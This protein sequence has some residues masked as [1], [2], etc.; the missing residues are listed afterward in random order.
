M[1]EISIAVTA[2]L[3]VLTLALARRF[4]AIPLLLGAT[5]V[6]RGAEMELG[7]A[8][9][10]IIRVLIAVG[11]VRV[12]LRG[13]HL[14]NGTNSIDRALVLWAIVLMASSIAHTPDAW[15]YRAGIVW[16]VLGS[17][18]LLRV[19]LRDW[20]DVTRIFK[21]LCIALVPVAVLMILE[22][23]TGHNFFAALG[24]DSQVVV[25]DGIVRARG[26]FA[27]PILAGTVG[28]TSVAMALSLW[29]S[30]RVHA[31]FGLLAASGILLACTSSG[32]AVSA[33]FV[34][35]GLML[36]KSRKKIRALVW[37]IA[38]GIAALDVVMQDPVYFLMARVDVTGSSTGW[39]RARL[40]QAAIEHLDEW[41]L[42]GTDYTRH[43]M[44][45]GIPANEL[46]ADITN[47]FLQMGVWGGLPLMLVFMLALA[48]AFRELGRAL[49]RN[50]GA[51]FEHRF[52]MWTV[53][54]ILFGYVVTFLSIS[55]F[56][57]SIVFFCLALAAI[58]AFDRGRKFSQVAHAKSGRQR[59]H[60]GAVADTAQAASQLGRGRS[61][62]TEVRR[63][64]PMRMTKL[65]E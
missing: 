32:P 60:G 53:G 22:K 51:A 29:P 11:V 33:L 26:P 64:T 38:L 17:Y 1:N 54:A 52:L 44:P 41:W 45:T 47:H 57:Q 23:W 7:P 40:I 5:F 31:L 46:H 2:V 24:G 48:L 30:H 61:V 25:R 21:V 43:W 65:S 9:M 39:Y 3:S 12:L 58:G 36:W 42:V 34:V 16:D 4:A 19:Y 13:E 62:E 50:K 10:T 28:A 18:L 49:R 27:H 37:I 55:V 14:A 63:S 15:L 20:K 59:I 8:H 56:D 6:T 35:F